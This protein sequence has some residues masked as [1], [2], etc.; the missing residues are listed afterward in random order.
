MFGNGAEGECENSQAKGPDHDESPQSAA[1][2]TPKVQP[3][4]AVFAARRESLRYAN[5]G[6]K[7]HWEL[8]AFF[9]SH[10]AF[11]AKTSVYQNKL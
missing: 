6:T 2:R 3:V 8:C 4:C 5:G 9:L 11:R 7:L 1:C 10:L